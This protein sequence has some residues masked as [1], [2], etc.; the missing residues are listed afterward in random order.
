MPSFKHWFSSTPA[1]AKDSDGLRQGHREAILDLLNY[2]SFADRDI[3]S[4][5]ETMIEGLETQLNWDPGQNFDYYLD[6]SIAAAREAVESK[7]QEY[8][9]QGIR[10]RLDTA[11]SRETAVRL[12]G[13]LFA[14]DGRDTK[15]DR[16][17]FA[18]VQAALA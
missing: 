11:K 18:A 7:D 8:F 1:A 5:E 3:S 10:R 17:V 14:A 15:A 6:K 12:C 13:K 9:L 16:T 2:C 4:S